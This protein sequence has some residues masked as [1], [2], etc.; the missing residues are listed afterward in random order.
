MSPLSLECLSAL[1]PEALSRLAEQGQQRRPL[2]IRN[3]FSADFLTE[4]DTFDAWRTFAEGVRPVRWGNFVRLYRGSELITNAE[5]FRPLPSD[6]S[7]DSYLGRL[8]DQTGSA[9]WGLC[10]T[11][12]HISN[13]KIFR[14]LLAFLDSLYR[15][16]GMPCSG[17]SPDLFMMNHKESFFRLHKDAQDVFTFIISGW[18]R[19]LLWPF[20]T[21]ATIAG[22][23][24]HESR[25][26]HRLVEVDHE[27]YRSQATV[28]E[29]TAGDLLYW[30]A[31]WWHVGESNGERAITLAVGTVHE[32]NPLQQ[33]LAAADRLGKRRDRR[34]N[35]RWSAAEGAEPT[36]TAYIDWIK[37]LL[38]D[39]DLWAETRRGL[40]SWTT[41]CGLRRVPPPLRRSA[42]LDDAQ[43][44]VVTSP[45]AIALDEDGEASLFCSIAGHDLTLTPGPPAKALL[46]ILSRG[47]THRVGAVIDKALESSRSTWSRE[48][49]R[50]LL[51]KIGDNYGFELLN[52]TSNTDTL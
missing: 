51:E 12:P 33:L 22:M 47:G 5:R 11:D 28:L 21:F 13:A 9:D 14:R 38:V 17:C 49:F 6:T 8:T 7:W 34:E 20:E 39:E 35:L 26:L 40:L 4:Q 1:S 42:P 23:E 25:E 29:G 43:W 2:V 10:L 3:A 32:A 27:A 24:A 44:L 30:P 41:R 50:R 45:S 46:T 48:E 31:E 16:I 19:F 18:R 37:S 52:S 36:I 15:Y